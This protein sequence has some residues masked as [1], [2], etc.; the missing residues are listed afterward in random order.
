MGTDIGF[1][2]LPDNTVMGVCL[3]IHCSCSTVMA[4]LRT[5][6]KYQS[7]FTVLFLQSLYVPLIQHLQCHLR[8][9]STDLTTWHC[10]T[11]ATV[12]LHAP[13]TSPPSGCLYTMAG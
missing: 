3:C 5:V 7:V 2:L 4:H 13:I 12:Q 9:V 6:H 8:L 11:L 10:L 1:K